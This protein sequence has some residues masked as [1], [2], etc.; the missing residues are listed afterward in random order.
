[1]QQER[2][3]QERLA[4]AEAGC[5]EDLR[6]YLDGLGVIQAPD[7]ARQAISEPKYKISWP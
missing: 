3:F 6:D 1:M 4:S 2:I 5:R 7:A